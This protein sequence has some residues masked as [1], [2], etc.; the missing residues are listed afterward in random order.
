MGDVTSKRREK[1]RTE[2]RQQILECGLDMIVSRGFGATKIRDIA[3]RLQIS[4]GLFFN[5]FESK[6]KLYEELVKVGL[7]GPASVLKLNTDE[8]EPIVLFEKM[9]E[10]IFESLRTYSVTAKMF[11]L[12]AQTIK[13]ETAPE[14]VK[15]LVAGFDVITPLLPVI[16]KGQQLGQIKAGDPTALAI[17]Y[18]GSVQGVSEYFALWSNLPLPQSSW[19][20]DVLRA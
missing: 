7:S 20:V 11:L 5:Y 17:A 4:V 19:I 12:M 9:T 10:V 15:K 8:I 18:W 1:Q 13:S 16:R 14:N 2:R 6:E 3:D